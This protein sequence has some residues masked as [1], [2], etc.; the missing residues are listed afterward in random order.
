MAQDDESGR[1]GTEGGRTVAWCVAEHMGLTIPNPYKSNEYRDGKT[2]GVIKSARLKNNSIKIPKGLYSRADK[3]L[4]AIEVVKDMFDIYELTKA[5]MDATKPKPPGADT[6]WGFQAN[7]LIAGR[8]PIDKV[9]LVE[10]RIE[11]YWPSKKRERVEFYALWA[12]EGKTERLAELPTGS[13]ILFYETDT[14]SFEVNQGSKTAFAY[15]TLTDT[16]QEE[17]ESFV[18]AKDRRWWE[19]RLVKLAA[20]VAPEK[21]VPL[22]EIRRITGMARL[23]MRQGPYPIFPEHFRAIAKK[24]G[25]VTVPKPNSP[26][27]P[28]QPQEKF[29]SISLKEELDSV[30]SQSQ[31]Q[32]QV[33]LIH[34]QLMNEFSAFCR[35]SIGIEPQEHR[36]DAILPGLTGDSTLLIEAKSAAAGTDGR[37]Q[38]RQAIGQLFDYR[39]TYLSKK[40]RVDLAV[41]LPEKPLDELLALLASLKIGVIWRE[42]PKF[43][44]TADVHALDERL[45]RAFRS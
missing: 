44:S 45:K 7:R 26:S 11:L 6:Q 29:R 2:V 23:R 37:H 4:I 21:G 38:I 14:D 31:G 42:G 13:Q 40:T 19:T 16:L 39:F 25:G 15:G 34:N 10:Y 5:E 3:A 17:P 32:A 8:K 24:L 27:N 9:R 41:L 18:D 20:W 30:R 33:K 43:R 12:N 28:E 1:E 22:A 35:K 36:F